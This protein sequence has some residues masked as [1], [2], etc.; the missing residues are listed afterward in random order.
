[1]GADDC[2]DEAAE[3]QVVLAADARERPSEAEDEDGRRHRLEA[4]AKAVAEGVERDDA[5][6]QVEDTREDEGDEGAEHER[7]GR[8][9]VRKC[10]RNRLALVDAA[11]VEHAVDASCDEH[12]ERQDEVDDLAVAE[13]HVGRLLL[14]V[15]ILLRDDEL[16]AVRADALTHRREV[17]GRPDDEE[18]EEDRQPSVEVKRDCLQEETEAVNRAVF[19][20]RGTDGGGP[21]RDWRDDADWRRRRIDDV[22]ELRARDLE[23]V[24]DRAHDGADSQ[25]VE[26]IVDEDDDA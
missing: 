22:G 19:R 13:L 25:A 21:A 16:L 10:L 23:L 5:A 12:E 26:V 1:M 9:A 15:S 3:V 7:L 6:R 24:R 2:A 4:P 18:H 14:G 20:Q 8:I 17:A 11:R